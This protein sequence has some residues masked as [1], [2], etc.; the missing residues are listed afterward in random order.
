LDASRAWR[1]GNTR[2]LIG[3]RTLSIVSHRSAAASSAF[4]AVTEFYFK[5]RYA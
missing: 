3:G 5:S 4:D 1:D 2:K